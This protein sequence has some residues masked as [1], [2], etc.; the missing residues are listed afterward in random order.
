MRVSFDAAYRSTF[1]HVS[2]SDLF[3]QLCSAKAHP[4]YISI[5]LLVVFA[6]PHILLLPVWFGKD[7]YHRVDEHTRETA[8][9]VLAAAPMRPQRRRQSSFIHP[10]IHLIY[11]RFRIK[12]RLNN[13]YTDFPLLLHSIFHFRQAIGSSQSTVP[14]LAEIAPRNLSRA[15]R[16]SAGPR[17]RMACL[18][19]RRSGVCRL[20]CVLCGG[21]R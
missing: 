13:L 7:A 8:Q 17:S 18:I 1:Q 3:T 21:E 16:C 5:A 14:S 15:H 2:F 9:R 19:L 20:R 4:Y 6:W 10:F 11:T 12:R